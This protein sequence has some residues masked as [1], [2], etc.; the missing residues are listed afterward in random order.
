MSDVYYTLEAHNF[1][2]I[3]QIVHIRDRADEQDLDSFR[4][5]WPGFNSYH[6]VKIETRRIRN[7][8]IIKQP[9]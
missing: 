2:G 5:D 1:E 4:S 7:T 6:L 9:V 8:Q 3:P